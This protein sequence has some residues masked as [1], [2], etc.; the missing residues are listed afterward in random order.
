MTT[1][2][3]L[4]PAI[5][6]A[7]SEPSGEDTAIPAADTLNISAYIVAN[8]P[9]ISS[10]ADISGNGDVDVEEVNDRGWIFGT[11]KLPGGGER[12]FLITMDSLYRPSGLHI[13]GDHNNVFPVDMSGNKIA[14]NRDFGGS[15]VG[16]VREFDEASGSFGQEMPAGRYSD[17]TLVTGLSGNMT[18][19][20]SYIYEE[21]PDYDQIG[22]FAPSLEYYWVPILG[23]FVLG[24]YVV[25]DEYW[26]GFVKDLET[27]SSRPVA[28]P[29]ALRFNRY[30]ELNDVSS[31]GSAVGA[32]RGKK[33]GDM[34]VMYPVLHNY[35]PELGT[36][37]TGYIL[38]G[39]AGYATAMNAYEEIVGIYQPPGNPSEQAF[40]IG[41]NCQDPIT[42]LYNFDIILPNRFI[43]TP[44][45][46]IN[47]QVIGTF[48]HNGEGTAGFENR[49]Y[50]YQH[51]DCGEGDFYNLD[52]MLKAQYPT[53][54][55]TLRVG[56]GIN[57]RSFAVGRGV[58]ASGNWF[59]WRVKIPNC[60]LCAKDE[61]ISW[62]Q[63]QPWEIGNKAF[64]SAD[65]ATEIRIINTEDES[66]EDEVYTGSE[67]ETLI[68]TNAYYFKKTDKYRI[69]I[70]FACG[71]VEKTRTIIANVFMAPIP[72]PTPDNISR[73]Q[74]LSAKAKG[75]VSMPSIEAPRFYQPQDAYDLL[76][77]QQER[78]FSHFMVETD[79]A[80]NETVLPYYKENDYALANGDPA[81]FSDII[82]REIELWNNANPD[83]AI[84]YHILTDVNVMDSAN[85][86]TWM[87]KY[88]AVW[89]NFEGLNEYGHEKFV[90]YAPEW[91]KF[92]ATNTVIA[93]GGH[94][95]HNYA[96]W[97]FLQNNDFFLPGDFVSERQIDKLYDIKQVAGEEG[98]ESFLMTGIPGFDSSTGQQQ[99]H[100]PWL[101]YM[102]DLDEK[103]AQIENLSQAHDSLT[104]HAAHMLEYLNAGTPT[105]K[106]NNF[107]LYR[108]SSL[109]LNVLSSYQEVNGGT[110][111]SFGQFEMVEFRDQEIFYPESFTYSPISTVSYINLNGSD[112][113]T[114]IALNGLLW[115]TA[116]NYLLSNTKSFDHA[117]M[118]GNTVKYLAN[119]V[120]TNFI[121]SPV[122]Q[123]VFHAKEQPYFRTSLDPADNAAV[124]WY[125]KNGFMEDFAPI[126][127]ASFRFDPDVDYGLIQFKAVHGDK[128]D[129]VWGNVANW[130]LYT[131]TPDGKRHLFDWDQPEA[132]QPGLST[133][134]GKVMVV[135]HGWQP[136]ALFKKHPTIAQ[137]DEGMERASTTGK[138][139]LINRWIADDYTVIEL[140]WVQIADM[141]NV[142]DVEK[143][144]WDTETPVGEIP[145]YDISWK[146]QAPDL[147]DVEALFAGIWTD[148]L[149]LQ[150]RPFTWFA[151]LI[152]QFIETKYANDPLV[153]FRMVGHSLGAGLS[154]GIMSQLLQGPVAGAP[155][156]G[157][158]GS[159][160]LQSVC[161]DKRIEWADSYWSSDY[162]N[163]IEIFVTDVVEND[164]V[165]IT[166]YNTTILFELS[167]VVGNVCQIITGNYDFVSCAESILNTTINQA[168]EKISKKRYGGLVI[169][170]A[171]AFK[172]VL[173]VI[174]II[175]YID[176][177]TK[178]VNNTIDNA[179]IRKNITEVK[180]DLQWV[181]DWFLA[182]P[183]L[184]E[185]HGAAWVHVLYNYTEAEPGI[186]DPEELIE[187]RFRGF[188]P[189]TCTEMIKRYRNLRLLRQ[190]ENDGRETLT[191]ADDFFYLSRENI[192]LSPSVESMYQD[193]VDN[194]WA[195]FECAEED[196]PGLIVVDD[197]IASPGALL[198]LADTIDNS[199][200]IDFAVGP[201]YELDQTRFYLAKRR[202]DKDLA[203]LHWTQAAQKTNFH[204]D[205]WYHPG[206]GTE[207]K[208]YDSVEWSYGNWVLRAE[209]FCTEDTARQDL[210]LLV[211]DHGLKVV[212]HEGRQ[213]HYNPANTYPFEELSSTR[214]TMIVVPGWDL[215]TVTDTIREDLVARYR[216]DTYTG[217]F[218]DWTQGTQ[219]G[220]PHNLLI[221]QNTQFFD[222]FV[223][224]IPGKIRDDNQEPISFRL[225]NGDYLEHE[226]A[227]TGALRTVF[228]EQLQG[229]LSS[230][231]SKDV[232]ILLENYSALYL[233]AIAD[234]II[235]GYGVNL[236]GSNPVDFDDVVNFRI[237]L[238]DPIIPNEDTY[239]MMDAIRTLDDYGNVAILTFKQGT[240]EELLH[241]QDGGLNRFDTIYS[242]TVY[243][244]LDVPDVDP[245]V[246]ST[247]REAMYYYL[248]SMTAPELAVY[249]TNEEGMDQS[250]LVGSYNG[251]SCYQTPFT[252]P[253][254]A[255]CFEIDRALYRDTQTY[256]ESYHFGRQINAF[257]TY[258]S[259]Q[260]PLWFQITQS[261]YEVI[262]DRILLNA[263][264]TA[265]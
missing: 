148:E 119:V 60:F 156:I 117:K 91:T 133:E 246:R 39:E 88:A 192:V 90:Q 203:D 36:Y 12:I 5:V 187:L 234:I 228:K 62:M 21:R 217:L 33:A 2:M 225:E 89:V 236:D 180:L 17:F 96:Q 76:I 243:T 251:T 238:A 186:I 147:G 31:D 211:L 226:V 155:G 161:V 235:A 257:T 134:T 250:L 175:E 221:Y 118:L 100:F 194:S 137:A 171:A 66:V 178:V 208:Y 107:Q 264:S 240:Q 138:E 78:A 121:V 216:N 10:L 130:G 239:E 252:A 44:D 115:G 189:S 201:G 80:G 142:Q 160:M 24:G 6:S 94:L 104:E 53:F 205:S 140:N 223:D 256:R 46:N 237:V 116:N 122:R 214:P 23:P 40:Y 220:L 233:P 164:D 72:R 198:A 50:V 263:I 261:P 54:D 34:E 247:N 95:H 38:N 114:T 9:E 93:T 146:H 262:D 101:E 145:E 232:R 112:A 84:S 20:N 144:M 67:L 136:N 181:D 27:G 18:S 157:G 128:E 81:I 70:D 159:E 26:R 28:F 22:D 16:F 64:R 97:G 231:N 260:E 125:Y 85:F 126:D 68:T 224:D 15:L 103:S 249:C 63:I 165:A 135:V 207:D 74:N 56:R 48:L 200:G 51:C 37:G 131:Y 193:F 168:N 35:I 253:A 129:I 124:Q 158:N 87:E 177:I 172:K 99:F 4:S 150:E 143:K 58:D 222:A 244:R 30:S 166:N 248:Y 43:T 230:N 258:E 245:Q 188:N 206:Y 98:E 255:N 191:S 153:E 127:P 241:P 55:W 105:S 167:D 184:A 141:I 265:Q 41:V 1:M 13:A 109:Y 69:E 29:M 49:A 42:E 102:I 210:P 108:S 202:K 106:E 19:T 254:A 73:Y 173:K 196:A 154:V 75:T 218:A 227:P 71:G 176:K 179:T 79:D 8:D 174:E 25:P 212:D 65:I 162:T 185:L 149:S 47:G 92:A 45:L 204:I 77:I 120:D 169:P 195:G 110:T 151:S 7:Q 209:H 11:Y 132:A 113:H 152:K 3:S 83:K 163:L 213:K 183:N 86:F 197:L 123:F 259:T 111:P 215:G 14:Y 190:W 57:D 229:Y 182:I 82:R 59:A 199:I 219:F 170:G 139:P 61:E 242:N 32:S 52:E